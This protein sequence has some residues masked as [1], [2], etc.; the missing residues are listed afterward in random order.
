MKRYLALL[1]GINISDNVIFS[2][3]EDDAIRFIK[4]IEEMIKNPFE[5][6]IPVFYNIERSP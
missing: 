4:Q 5:L 6:A 1:R 2:S 3:N